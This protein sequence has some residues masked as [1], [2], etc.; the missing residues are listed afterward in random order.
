VAEREGIEPTRAAELLSTVLKTAEAT[1]HPSPS[2]SKR[3]VYLKMG[4]QFIKLPVG[5]NDSDFTA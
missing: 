2:F 3:D 5:G 4:K 1:R